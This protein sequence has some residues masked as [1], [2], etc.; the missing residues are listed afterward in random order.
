MSGMNRRTFLQSTG[1]GA[2]GLGVHISPEAAECD[3][4]GRRLRRPVDRLERIRL[5]HNAWRG[6]L[7][8]S[9]R[10]LA[11]WNCG[12]DGGNLTGFKH[13]SYQGEAV[14]DRMH[15]VGRALHALS[16]AEFVT[17]R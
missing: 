11:Y 17:G 16:L 14:W 15:D 9:R 1:L 3:G 2:A 4:T 7:E 8:A 13:S 6:G 5:G 10:H 12:F